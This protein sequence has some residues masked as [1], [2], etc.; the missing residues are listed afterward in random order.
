M[1]LPIIALQVVTVERASQLAPA[2]STFH[3]RRVQGLVI[4]RD[5]FTSSKTQMV[6]ELALQYRFLTI[7]DI[8]TLAAQGGLITYGYTV[9]ADVDRLAADIVDKILRGEKAGEIPTQQATRFRLII[10]L[11]TANALRLT[12]PPALTARADELIR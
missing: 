4:L 10:N 12:L 7:S 9:V 3:A 1:C 11:V 5:A 2:F 6:A 8:P